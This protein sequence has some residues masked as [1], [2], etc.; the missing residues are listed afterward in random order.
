MPRFFSD[1]IGTDEVLLSPED[2]LHIGRSLRMRIGE[3]IVVCDQRGNDYRC[4]LSEITPRQVTAK[5]LEKYPSTTEPTVKV[6]LYQC[7]PKADKLELVI[8]KATELGVHSVIPVLS[9]RC[10][11][12]PDEKSFAKKRERYQRIADAAAKQAGRG[13]I[14]QVLPLLSFRQA[15]EQMAAQGLSILLY[16]R[17]GRPFSSLFPIQEKTISLLVGSEGGFSPEEAN[18]AVE[19]GITPIHLGP[20]I[21]RT[22][23]APLCALSVLMYATGNL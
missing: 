15:V 22:E 23:T 14:P 12:R 21:L 6:R 8:Q 17:E 16:E 18:Y 20:R 5:I 1:E 2:S 9:E 11:S 10:I 19:R 13:I 4:V 7:M 3:E